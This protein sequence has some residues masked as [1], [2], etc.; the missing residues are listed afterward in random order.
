VRSPWPDY[1]T[2][3]AFGTTRGGHVKCPFPQHH[4]NGDAHP[5]AGVFLAKNKLH[6]FV[7]GETWSTID[8]VKALKGLDNGEAIKWLGETFHLREKESR[9]SFKG[10]GKV[11]L[12]AMQRKIVAPSR[13]KKPTI[14]EQILDSPG[15]AALKPATVKVGLALLSKMPEKNPVVKLSQRE[16]M[17]M[18]GYKDFEPIK[19]AIEELQ[20]NRDLSRPETW[21]PEDYVQGNSTGPGLQTV[22]GDWKTGSPS[23]RESRAEYRYGVLTY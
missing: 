16:L 12:P 14:I 20:S 7:S 21:E 19:K 18:T 17:G 15:Y 1:W 23:A 11:G 6:C 13:K 8:L 10:P 3:W 4:R 5:S 2:T 22:G 9:V